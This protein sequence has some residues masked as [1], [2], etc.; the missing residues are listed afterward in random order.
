MRPPGRA[1]E[2]VREMFE[3]RTDPFEGADW[4][5]ARRIVTAILGLSALLSLAFLPLEPV[6]EELG[7][8]GWA[9]AG[10]L[11]ALALAGTVALSR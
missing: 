5:S 10:A 9:I 2:F 6:D 4:N 7:A 3:R 1:V 8:A 11:L